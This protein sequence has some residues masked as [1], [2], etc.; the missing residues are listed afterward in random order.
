MVEHGRRWKWKVR[1]EN[2]FSVDLGNFLLL[3]CVSM[4]LILFILYDFGKYYVCKYIHICLCSVLFSFL[5]LHRQSVY[6]CSVDRRFNEAMG[7]KFSHLKRR[8]LIDTVSK[9]IIRTLSDSYLIVFQFIYFANKFK[10]N[11]KVHSL[12]TFSLASVFVLYLITDWDSKYTWTETSC[13]TF[14]VQN[15]IYAYVAWFIL[16]LY[17][18]VFTNE[19]INLTPAVLLDSFNRAVY[20]DKG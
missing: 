6:S 7:L 14:A 10:T 4:I 17:L 5:N 9:H 1:K 15:E 18:I 13:R 11:Y 19:R 16:I 8:K 2:T 20:F 12:S 3:V